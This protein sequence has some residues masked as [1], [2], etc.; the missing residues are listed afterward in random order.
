MIRTNPTEWKVKNLIN[1]LTQ[2]FE[3]LEK[4]FVLCPEIEQVIVLFGGTIFSP[5]ESY[6]INFPPPCPDADCLPLAACQRTLFKHIIGEDILG[7]FS[8]SVSPTNMTLLLS[9]P[10][11]CPLNWFVPKQSFTSPR[12]GSVVTFNFK[13]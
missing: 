4:A 9:A 2:I 10:R 5:K 7:M 12:T 11:S 1:D 6:L 3:H 13:C 8:S